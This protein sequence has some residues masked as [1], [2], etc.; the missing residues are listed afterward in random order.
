M[1]EF[2]FMGTEWQ[3]RNEETLVSGTTG[4]Q[5]MFIFDDS[6]EDVARIAVFVAG[7]V[8]RT[9]ELLGNYVAIPHEVLAQP[10]RRLYVGVYG[11]DDDGFIRPTQMI[12]GPWIEFGAD[13]TLDPG[14]TG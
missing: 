5:V 8:C 9:V 14:Y 4:K 12:P 2:R 13:P 7:T 10:G 6:W 11:I 1:M 3:M